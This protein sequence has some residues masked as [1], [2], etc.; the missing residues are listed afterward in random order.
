MYYENSQNSSETYSNDGSICDMEATHQGL[1]EE[2]REIS[3]QISRIQLKINKKNKSKKK[4][5]K[6]LK[7]LKLKEQRKA[8]KLL[9]L[10]TLIINITDEIQ[11]KKENLQRLNDEFETLM[12]VNQISSDSDSDSSGETNGFPPPLMLY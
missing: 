10:A 8:N 6:T 7:K 3:V 11:L 12:Q 1:K 5:S 9:N 2:S 4:K